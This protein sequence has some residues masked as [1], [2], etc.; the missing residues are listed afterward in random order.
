MATPADAAPARAPRG[1]P[2]LPS[3]RAEPVADRRL[4]LGADPL[5]GG[6]MYMHEVR[7][8]PLGHAAG[9]AGARLHDGALVARRDPRG[10]HRP[11]HRRGL[12]GLRIGMALFITSEVL[13]FFAFFWAYFWGALSRPMDGRGLHLAARGR[14][15]GRDL[16][17]P[18]PQ[19]HDPAAL[20]LHGDLGAPRGAR[21]RQ[22]RPRSRRWRSRW[23]SACCSRPSRPTS[24]STPSTTPRAS[25]SRAGS[26]AR[27]STWRPA[28]TAST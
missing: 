25:R 9:G 8:R 11:P 15:S 14:P 1:P 13:F 4:A 24:T 12:K 26:S 23:R 3:G 20:G 16:G 22:P 10:P 6:V 28:S 7:R 21:E 2:P 18:V 27:P 19:H 5:V 17:H